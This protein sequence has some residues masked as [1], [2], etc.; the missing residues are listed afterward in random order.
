MP[1]LSRKEWFG[2]LTFYG[3]AV[4][5]L[6]ALPFVGI[7]FKKGILSIPG[8][9]STYQ[10][11]THHIGQWIT[12][13]MP[14]RAGLY[15]AILVGVGVLYFLSEDI[16][17][18]IRGKRDK[19][20][21]KD[22]PIDDQIL[23]E[24]AREYGEK[25]PRPLEGSPMKTLS[26]TDLQKELSKTKI[27]SDIQKRILKTA[28]N[29][30]I[31][32]LENRTQSRFDRNFTYSRVIYYWI[33]AILMMGFAWAWTMATMYPGQTTGLKP[34]SFIIIGISI[35]LFYLANS[36]TKKIFLDNQHVWMGKNENKLFCE[37]DYTSMY[38]M[39]V[40]VR[41]FLSVRKTYTLIVFRKRFCIPP[42]TYFIDRFFPAS[43]QNRQVIFMN[44]WKDEEG[45]MVA[46]TALM[47][48]ILDHCDSNG[49]KV[50][51]WP[52]EAQFF[53]MAILFFLGLFLYIHYR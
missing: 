45:K 5:F 37:K 53:M 2:L 44:I 6:V 23:R 49:V 30:E 18:L 35:Y 15:F 27:N 38:Y 4:L 1:K 22:L 14:A 32:S 43:N 16:L 26:S 51:Y 10:N 33:I 36:C 25:E 28:K 41:N 46:D 8:L 42:L 20:P 40:L 29:Q 7:M 24:V 9:K 11:I 48:R 21:E 17:N 34:V 52:W 19:I 13:W 3:I 12:H 31:A 39:N 47:Q 50:K